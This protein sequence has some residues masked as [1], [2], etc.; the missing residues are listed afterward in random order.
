MKIKFRLNFNVLDYLVFAV[1]ALAVAVSFYVASYD[2]GVFV[3]DK[4]DIEYILTVDDISNELTDNIKSGDTLY[5]KFTALAIGTVKDVKFSESYV[6]LYDSRADAYVDN[7][8]IS[9]NSSRLTVTVS[10]RAQKNNGRISV[11]GFDLY[12]GMQLIFRTP[13]LEANAVCVSIAEVNIQNNT[14]QEKGI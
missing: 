2:G 11:N 13:D 9:P 4:T 14:E 5:D 7:S 1:V 12:N 6:L 10:A 3:G 8:V